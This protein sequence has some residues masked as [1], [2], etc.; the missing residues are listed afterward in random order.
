MNIIKNPKFK[1]AMYLVLSFIMAFC[2][3]VCALLA[4]FRFTLLKSDFLIGTLNKTDYYADLSDEI[5]ENLES[6]G[7]SSGL[8]KSFFSDFIDDTVLRRDVET[9][10]SAFYSGESLRVNTSNFQKTLR[11]ALDTYISKNGIDSSKISDYSINNFIKEATD[12]YSSS[13]Q[14][15]YFSSIQKTVLGITPKVNIFIFVTALI[16][17]G[18][19]VLIILTNEWK[20]IAVRHIYYSTASSGLFLLAIPA[21]VFATGMISKL[22]VLTRSLNDMYTACLKSV[23]TVI[24]VIAVLL[25]VISAAL[26]IIH[27]SLRKK[28]SS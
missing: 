8:D 27:S 1:T 17:I 20:H 23:F 24:L 22:T 13:V 9:F 21:V 18:I 3:I 16:A 28:A 26:W 4:A 14:L 5:T 11:T 7:D 19:A 10:I 25:I 12:I 6:I 2:I 15:K